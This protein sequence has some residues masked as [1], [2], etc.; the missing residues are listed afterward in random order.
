[1]TEHMSRYG[2]MRLARTVR[3]PAGG[4]AEA[5]LRTVLR[6]SYTGVSLHPHRADAH[7]QR[8]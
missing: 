4:S 7:T 2:S 3:G 6:S 5:C 1:M 8:D